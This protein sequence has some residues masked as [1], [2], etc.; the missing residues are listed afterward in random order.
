MT[1]QPTD[2]SGPV[3]YETPFAAVP[4]TPDIVMYE[5]NERAFSSTGNFAGIL[6]RLDSIKALGVNVLWLMPIH[7]IGVTKTVNS[8]Y[9]VADYQKVN[10]EYGTLED[11]RKLV[12]EAHN[13]KMA[14]VLDWVANHTSWDNP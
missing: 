4:N 9:C 10:P 7:P 1:L 12:R 14:V 13:R 3:Q 8:P 5:I 6:P 11:L 2:P